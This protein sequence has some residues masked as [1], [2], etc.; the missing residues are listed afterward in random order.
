MDVDVLAYGNLDQEEAEELVDTM[1]SSLKTRPLFN[2]EVPEERTM[3][4]QPG[5]T[6]RE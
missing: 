5:Q 6:V 2:G 1:S 3:E 4:L